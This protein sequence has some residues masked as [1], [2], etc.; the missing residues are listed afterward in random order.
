M[1]PPTRTRTSRVY[2]R[3]CGEAPG[4][5]QVDDEQASSAAIDALVQFSE[6]GTGR[7]SPDPDCLAPHQAMVHGAE[8]VAADAKQIQDA[9]RRGVT[10]ELV[11]DQ[12]AR[13][14]LHLPSPCDNRGRVGSPR[15]P[16]TT[17]TQPEPWLRG[18]V[19]GFEPLLM[20]VVHAF[21]QV[22]EDVENLVARVQAEHAWERP[23]G[24]ASIG[25]H[26]RHLGGALDRLFTYARGE[27]LSDTQK[28][29][30]RAEGDL[31][32]PAPA[33][34]DVAADMNA[35]IERA[36]EQLRTTTRDD[37]LTAR[38]VGRAGLPT[39]TLGLLFHAAEH[40]TRHA[41]QAISTAKILAGS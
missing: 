11:R 4:H 32:D 39:T 2:P 6:L 19:D 36:L 38:T 21:I 34:A 30:M 40:S 15:S 22:R 31:V 8:Q 13:E 20:P 5:C 29:A 7:V 35:S 9:V 12:T 37:L 27:A 3:E 10:A 18:P 16:M 26:V 24:A 41:G 14:V 1:T 17:L 33:L 25:F 23:G 28:A